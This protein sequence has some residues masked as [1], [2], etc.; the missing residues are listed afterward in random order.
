MG[1]QYHN[2]S[3]SELTNVVT[4]AKWEEIGASRF[5]FCKFWQIRETPR[6]KPLGTGT[7]IF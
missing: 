7:A 6:K 5:V 1:E 2:V 3:I 4:A